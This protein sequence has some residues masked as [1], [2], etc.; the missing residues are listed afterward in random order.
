MLAKEEESL[1]QTDGGNQGR[2]FLSLGMVAGVF[3]RV[4]RY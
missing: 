2:G 4:H 3:H 1:E